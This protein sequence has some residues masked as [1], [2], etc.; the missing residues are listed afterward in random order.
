[1]FIVITIFLHQALTVIFL[2]QLRWNVTEEPV[3]GSRAVYSVW[4]WDLLFHRHPEQNTVLQNTQKCKKHGYK[5]THREDGRR[6]CVIRRRE[7]KRE[8]K[9]F[10]EKY[11]H[12]LERKEILDICQR[13]IYLAD[14]I[15]SNVTESWHS[16]M[17]EALQYLKG[18]YVEVHFSQYTKNTFK[19]IVS[20]LD[21]DNS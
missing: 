7:R 10:T 13:G 20:C 1:M 5:N 6:E 3:S 4:R 8:S 9:T 21:L 15:I 17:S 14:V 2:F 16:S 12:K 19:R 11:F 18:L